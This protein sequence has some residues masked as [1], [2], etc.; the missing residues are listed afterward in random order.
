MKI[1]RRVKEKLEIN[2]ECAF[3]TGQESRERIR[4]KI[5]AGRTNRDLARMIPRRLQK[6]K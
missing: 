3:S 2:I 4:L 6:P 1:G 5:L